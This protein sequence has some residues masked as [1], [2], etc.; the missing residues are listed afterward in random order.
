MIMNIKFEEVSLI[1]NY[2]MINEE[3]Y[4]I[5]MNASFE[6]GKMY[7]IKGDNDK[8]LLSKLIMNFI[9]PT[10]GTIY[11]GDY[12]LQRGKYLKNIKSLRRHI[13]YLPYDYD[14]KFNYKL[15]NN[16]FKEILYNYDYQ[17]DKDNELV[18]D[19][20]AKTGCY[21]DYKNEK[22]ENLD[23]ITRYKLYLAS[24]LIINPKIIIVEKIINDEKIKSYLD[25]LAHEEGKIVIFIGNCNMQVDKTYMVKDK[26]LEEVKQ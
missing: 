21:L 10:F 7:L 8:Y 5:K 18:E 12:K 23:S 3:A 22:L 26:K 9:E 20:I 4:F 25:H 15:V 17:M 13:G 14:E 24:L 19:I 11:I 1:K 2:R 16:I 6:S